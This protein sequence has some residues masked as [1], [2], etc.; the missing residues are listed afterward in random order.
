MARRGKTIRQHEQERKRR[1]FMAAEADRTCTTCGRGTRFV[2]A[3]ETMECWCGELVIN[4]VDLKRMA[5]D[6]VPV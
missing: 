5:A 2:V 4:L 3:R 1:E 6:A